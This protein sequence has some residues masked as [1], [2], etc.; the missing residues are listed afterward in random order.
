MAGGYVGGYN[1]NFKVVCNF[2]APEV[3]ACATTPIPGSGDPPLQVVASLAD[4]VNSYIIIDAIGKFI[5]LYT[6]A[7]GNEVLQFLIGG[8]TNTDGLFHALP[9]GARISL[10]HMGPTAITKGSLVIQFCRK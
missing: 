10:R 5:G 3:L 9:R 7:I 6:G 8:G 4:H 1:A 2:D